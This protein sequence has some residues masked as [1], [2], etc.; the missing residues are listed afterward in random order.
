[1][2]STLNVRGGTHNSC[3][4]SY[5][6]RNSG[7][8]IYGGVFDGCSTGRNSHWASKTFAY[9]FDDIPA[10]PCEDDTLWRVWYKMWLITEC[11]HLTEMEWLATCVLFYYDIEKKSLTV[12]VLGD[13]AYY[14]NHT[15]HEIDQNNQPDYFGYTLNHL[16]L[17]VQ[18]YFDRYPSVT[19]ENVT[20]FK[21]CS[22]GIKSFSRSQF[23]K[24]EA[25]HPDPIA[26]LFQE[27]DSLN[28]LERRFNM[29][30]NDQYTINDDLTIIS[31]GG[32]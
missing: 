20:N 29:L 11:L 32:K 15:E 10:N 31:Y 27:P 24:Q 5:F 21:I 19:Y 14:V 16:V 28:C 30:R 25:K 23:A 22:D 26:L 12:R 17:Q 4:D 9:M 18:K 1:M 2:L 3:E 8:A 6:I 7:D 13:G